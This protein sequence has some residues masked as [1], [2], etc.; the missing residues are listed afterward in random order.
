MVRHSAQH[1]KILVRESGVLTCQSDTS[2]KTSV[3]F[4]LKRVRS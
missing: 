2:A 3:Q 4:I 1:R